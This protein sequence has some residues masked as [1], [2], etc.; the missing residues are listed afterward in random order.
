MNASIRSPKSWTLRGSP[1]LV[2]CA[3]IAVMG[4]AC[5]GTSPAAAVVTAS[6]RQPATPSPAPSPSLATSPSPAA[7]AYSGHLTFTGGVSGTFAVMAPSGGSGKCGAGEVDVAVVIRGAEWDISASVSPFNGAGSYSV[8]SGFGVLIS[9]PSFDLWSST[10]GTAVYASDRS[11][12]VDIDITNMMA[13]P[14]E[15]GANAHITGTMSC[16]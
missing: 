3:V 14:G 1:L 2:V 7:P 13:G 4:T 5:G 15:P 10:G 6:A 12:T 8:A 9:T 16:G 11:V